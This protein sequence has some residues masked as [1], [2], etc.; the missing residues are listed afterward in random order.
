MSK[1]S[2]LRRLR[3]YEGRQANTVGGGAYMPLGGLG[4][5]PREQLQS[6]Q[7]YKRNQ[8]AEQVLLT[9]ADG[10]GYL[11][12]DALREGAITDFKTLA[13][14]ALVAAEIIYPDVPDQ[15]EEDV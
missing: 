6:E 14:A 10:H 5:P 12:S 13:Q 11:D 2:L 9:I 15:E 3:Q 8:L 1:T 7:D 4:L